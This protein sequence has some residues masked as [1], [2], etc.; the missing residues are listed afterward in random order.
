MNSNSPTLADEV[1]LL[2]RE[3]HRCFPVDPRLP[4]ATRLAAATGDEWSLEHIEETLHHR[5]WTEISAQDLSECGIS[6]LRSYLTR[7]GFR[8]YLP[9]LLTCGLNQLLSGD[10]R[11]AELLPQ[12]LLPTAPE[13][14]RVRQY[15]GD[16]LFSDPI[17]ATD[18]R[19]L[20]RSEY[21]HRSLNAAQ[22]R[23]VGFYLDLSNRLGDQGS[24][25]A[26]SAEH[27]SLVQ[28]WS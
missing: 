17:R 13:Y 14:E 16:G 12:M 9:A 25:G 11:L 18:L 28:Y 6:A 22:R 10:S 19:L 26:A 4:A 7:E 23:C 21:V 3:I 27:K 2:N 24:S 20:E 1:A 15:Y 8:Y 5:G